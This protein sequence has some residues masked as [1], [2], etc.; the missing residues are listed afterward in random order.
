M[1]MLGYD[2]MKRT[3]RYSL[4]FIA[5]LALEAV[6]VSLIYGSGISVSLCW[7]FVFWIPIT[8]VFFVFTTL[9]FR[10]D[11]RRGFARMLNAFCG[12]CVAAVLWTS[13][14]F[15][16]LIKITGAGTLLTVSSP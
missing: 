5:L 3:L 4:A 16:T 8:L 12:G 9:V 11:S 2:R 15:F 10:D 14:V 13:I 1:T 6:P 7:L